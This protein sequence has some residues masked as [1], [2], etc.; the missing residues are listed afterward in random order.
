MTTGISVTGVRG[1]SANTEAGIVTVVVYP[2]IVNGTSSPPA[3]ASPLA[4]TTGVPSA[5]TVVVMTVVAV[6]VVVAV[7]AAKSCG[8]GKI[9]VVVSPDIVNVYS[10]KL[11]AGC[12]VASEARPSRLI[13]PLLRLS[14]SPR[15]LRARMLAAV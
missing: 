15:L 5:Y 9:T 13:L 6:V 7:A 10:A 3:F 8:T 11:C 4:A 1:C 2:L 14:P 12:A